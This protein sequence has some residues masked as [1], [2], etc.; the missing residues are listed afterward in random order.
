MSW[1]VNRLTEIGKNQAGL[2]RALNLPQQR[3]REMNRGLRRIQQDEWQPLAEYLEWTIPELHKASGGMQKT[4]LAGSGGRNVTVST[5]PAMKIGSFPL[6][7]EDAMPVWW[8]K[9]AGDG[10]LHMERR[11][12]GMIPRTEFL[13]YA[14]YSFGLE[15]MHD[16]MSPA[17]ERRDVVVVNPDRAVVP[18]DDVLVVQDYEERGTGGFR[19]MLRRLVRE[20]D[21]HWIV[22]QFTPA[23]EYKLAK[24]EWPRIL[25]IAGKRAR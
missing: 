21:T 13:R 8:G 5:A 12:I 20:T 15:V 11:I 18:G 16:D 1:L 10:V 24:T 4:P 6:V 22:R 9:P 3:V 17:F 25:H 14:Q 19:A 23:R 2:A 7:V